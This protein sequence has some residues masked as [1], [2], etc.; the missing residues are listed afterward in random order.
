VFGFSKLAGKGFFREQ[1]SI[2]PIPKNRTPDPDSTE[3]RSRI[4]KN[5]IL[6]TL[7]VL[8]SKGLGINTCRIKCIVLIL[9]S[10]HRLF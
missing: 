9:I 7:S 2:R 8:K 6:T 3:F 5:S 1:H 4:R 10:C